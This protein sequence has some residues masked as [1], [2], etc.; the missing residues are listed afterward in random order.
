MLN[1]IEIVY[2]RPDTKD[3]S[4]PGSLTDKYATAALKAHLIFVSAFYPWLN[5]SIRNTWPYR[6]KIRF[7]SHSYALKKAAI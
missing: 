6:N 4:N 3:Y 1:R 2:F 7:I 5:T